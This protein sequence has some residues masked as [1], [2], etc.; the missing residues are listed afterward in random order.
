MP[1][2]ADMEP[3]IE[4]DFTARE[5]T[6]MDIDFLHAGLALSDMS[7]VRS[8]GWQD[9]PSNGRVFSLT[10]FETQSSYS[11]YIRVSG[12]FLDLHD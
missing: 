7:R 4:G 12:C 1:L 5:L 11:N 2:V 10:S 3:S 9:L 6:R 8:S